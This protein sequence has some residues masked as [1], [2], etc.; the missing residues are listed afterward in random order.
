MLVGICNPDLRILKVDY[1]STTHSDE[2]A[3]LDQQ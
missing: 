2:I 1:K 3:N